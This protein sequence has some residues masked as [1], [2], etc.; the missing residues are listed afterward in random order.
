VSWSGL[1]APAGTPLA[2]RE[3]IA[4]KVT[5][6]MRSPEVQERLRAQ[7]T[8]GLGGTPQELATA[9]AR[10]Y[11]RYGKVIRTLNIQLD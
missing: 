3:A 9:I 11:E 7:G 2:L 1:M 6:A 10:D 5:A 8:V 4:R